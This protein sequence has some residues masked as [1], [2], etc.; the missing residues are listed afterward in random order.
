[1]GRKKQQVEEKEK[2]K[3]I[4]IRLYLPEKDHARMLAAAG[5]RGLALSAYAR[6][7]VLLAVNSDLD[8]K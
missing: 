8:E 5:R 6:Q 7:A 1:M 4:P 2:L 3:Q